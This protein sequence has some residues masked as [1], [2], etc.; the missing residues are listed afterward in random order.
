MHFHINK[1]KAPTSGTALSDSL[2]V[3]IFFSS[4][5]TAFSLFCFRRFSMFCCLTWVTMN[6]GIW[7]QD[8]HREWWV[9]LAVTHF[10][11]HL[12][13]QKNT[14]RGQW[15]CLTRMQ[16]KIVISIATVCLYWC[17]E[18]QNQ[19]KGLFFILTVHRRFWYL[20]SSR[21]M[22]A[23]LAAM[24]NSCCSVTLQRKPLNMN[25]LGAMITETLLRVILFLAWWSITR[26]KN[27]TSA[28]RSKQKQDYNKLRF[29]PKVSGSI[30]PRNYIF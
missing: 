13:L 23:V 19:A 4:F 18:W 11:D 9:I 21:T 25:M 5:L 3:V 6:L 24:E 2:S 15:L 29:H 17:F 10:T 7:R 14:S 26:W 22:L 28:W 30:G 27:S 16:C 20:I 1:V 12:T 8:V